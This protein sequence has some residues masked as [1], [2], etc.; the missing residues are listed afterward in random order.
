MLSF[1]LVFIAA[2]VIGTLA[3]AQIIGS[4][5]HFGEKKTYL[6]TLILWSVLVIYLAYAAISRFHQAFAV[7]AAYAVALIAVLR[8][9]KSKKE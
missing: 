1:L 4:I 3:F 8:D 9:N 7:F 6:L 5:K 2:L